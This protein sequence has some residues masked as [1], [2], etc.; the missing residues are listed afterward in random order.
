MRKRDSDKD[1]LKRTD[2]DKQDHHDIWCDPMEGMSTLGMN[3]VAHVG[4]IGIGVYST[5]FNGACVHVD[6]SGFTKLSGKYCRQG[7]EGLDNLHQVTNGL[8]AQLV[9]I[10][11]F[12]S[13]DVISFAGDALICVFRATTETMKTVH[14]NNKRKKV[15]DD[16]QVSVAR[17]LKCCIALKDYEDNDLTVHIGLSCGE[18]CFT[19]LGGY[20]GRWAYLLNGKC[21]KELASCL[22]DA[23]SKQ[24]VMTTSAYDLLRGSLGK[25]IASVVAK[26]LASGNYLFESIFLNCSFSPPG[27]R[28]LSLPCNKSMTSAVK[29]FI[30]QT[31]TGAVDAGSYSTMA[32]LRE[33]TALFLSLDSYTAELYANPATLQSFFLIVQEAME[34]TGGFM[35]QFLID[36]KGC[37][38][39]VMWGVPSFSYENNTARAVD[40]AVMIDERAA[41]IAHRC[42]VGITTGSVYCGNIGSVVRRDYVGIGETVNIA[43]RLMVKAK[44]RVLMD[45]ATY[46]R[47]PE[48]GQ[49]NIIPVECMMLK[50]VGALTP[51][52]VADCKVMPRIGA[53]EDDPAK[54][55]GAFLLRGELAGKLRSQLQDIAMDSAFVHFSPRHEEVV[56]AGPRYTYNNAFG[57]PSGKDSEELS[58]DNSGGL[59]ALG[60]IEEDTSEGIL[61][62]EPSAIGFLSKSRSNLSFKA[63]DD[64]RRDTENYLRRFTITP[65]AMVAKVKFTLVRGPPGCGKSTAARYF[66]Q[67]ASRLNIQTFSLA[68][69]SGGNLQPY[70]MITKLLAQLIGRKML[71]TS[72]KARY[73]LTQMI[74][75]VDVNIDTAD[76]QSKAEKLC[77]LMAEKQKT[78]S[79]FEKVDLNGVP[80]QKLLALV[81]TNRACAVVIENAHFIDE[82]SWQ[83]LRILMDVETCLSLL[84]TIRDSHYSFGGNISKARRISD[85]N[86]KLN[87]I[88]GFNAPTGK[89]GSSPNRP[90]QGRKSISR[91]IMSLS[92]KSRKDLNDNSAM[93]APMLSSPSGGFGGGPVFGA[94]SGNARAFGVRSINSDAYQSILTSSQCVVV[95][96]GPLSMEDVKVLLLRMMPSKDI[97]EDLV[98]YLFE[99]SVGSPFWCKAIAGYILETG[100]EAFN[101]T[102]VNKSKYSKKTRT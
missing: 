15:S 42:S 57:A 5:V 9:Q 30:P 46:S 33:V 70:G 44:G 8:L 67:Q 62:R 65:A 89:A 58:F 20:Q 35:R 95:D 27:S 2:S 81:L 7:V 40:C 76:A 69:R 28:L 50:G 102:V 10:V 79:T 77:Q 82:L 74:K 52:A 87:K 41:S 78:T 80:I 16:L 32:E 26:Q 63:D 64:L 21:M 94:A 23:Q 48:V 61:S 12:H 1:V 51:Y 55:D 75:M 24:V 100:F 49:N 60:M 37:V 98:L 36:D 14:H 22:E 54:R 85:T 29:S 56:V 72:Y 47:L 18:M 34:D 97:T 83:Q 68:A 59:G 99:V 11:I 25:L 13:G 84:L 93:P 4:D 101:D 31:V 92:G 43:A 6:I 53:T 86:A 91:L 17:A 96:V 90:E 88:L 45:K 38:L 66:L 3:P 73:V 39:I 71:Q 19:T